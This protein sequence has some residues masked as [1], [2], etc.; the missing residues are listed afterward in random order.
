MSKIDNLKAEIKE[1][2]SILH[3]KGVPA[4]E[5]ESA[6]DEIKALKK[7]IE[8]LEAKEAAIKNMQ[9]EKK[10]KLRKQ[11]G[12]TKIRKIRKR[13]A[14]SRK[15]G[16]GLK[17]GP[18]SK[19]QNPKSKKRANMISVS[20]NVK[21]FNKGRSASNIIR[22]KQ[23]KSMSPG[24][25][26]SAEGN[27]YYE[28]RPNRSDVSKRDRLEKGGSLYKSGGKISK[29]AKVMREFKAGTLKSSSGD[30]VTD[31]RQAL[32]I[33]FSESRKEKMQAS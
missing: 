22:D 25:R 28:K 13:V 2:E 31:K 12:G 30:P 29:F 16:A 18:K 27:T 11:V 5:K 10:K 26:T 8:T 6:M 32:A 19:I 23:R 3:E 14:G 1:Y 33:A 20:T 9:A 4:D 15:M 17:K 21:R 7:E 24:K